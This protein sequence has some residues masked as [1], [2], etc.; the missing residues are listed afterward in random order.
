MSAVWTI[1]SGTATA[2]ITFFI[3][4]LCLLDLLGDIKAKKSG[5]LYTSL[6]ENA[7]SVISFVLGALFAAGVCTAIYGIGQLNG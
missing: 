2:A 1:V 6:A 3:F 5:I 4:F 7:S